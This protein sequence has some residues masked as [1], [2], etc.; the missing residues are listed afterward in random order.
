MLLKRQKRRYIGQIFFIH[1][2]KDK[3][4][5][6]KMIY[7]KNSNGWKNILNGNR[8]GK[9]VSL[10]EA[11]NE[12]NFSFK[13]YFQGKQRLFDDEDDDSDTDFHIKYHLNGK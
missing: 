5:G 2:Y 10:S 1:V 8:H 13:G 3:V 6:P 7:C 11:I 4:Y 9:E 12:Y